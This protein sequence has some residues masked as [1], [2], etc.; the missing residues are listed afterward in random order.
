MRVNL[1]LS[2]KKDK[3]LYQ[4]EKR[5]GNRNFTKLVRLSLKSLID[6]SVDRK[7]IQKLLS[8]TGNDAKGVIGICFTSKKDAPLAALVENIEPGSRSET[9]KTII[10]FNIGLKEILPC[11]LKDESMM[12]SFVEWNTPTIT[13][14]STTQKPKNKQKAKQV[15][16]KPASI[17]QKPVPTSQPKPSVEIATPAEELSF[18]DIQTP[19]TEEKKPEVMTQEDVLAMLDGI[20]G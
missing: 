19:D 2:E 10:R 6:A 12:D 11:Y 3:D 13:R 14:V 5:I 8:A 17:R 9:I 4:I 16:T 20:L 15:R 7:E 18:D 1:R